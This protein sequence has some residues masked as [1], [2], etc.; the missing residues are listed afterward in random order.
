MLRAL[1][2]EAMG[3]FL[4]VFCSAMIERMR[5]LGMIGNEEAFGKGVVDFLV[6]V[7][8]YH[9]GSRVSGC[10]L[11]P[12]VSFGMVFTPKFTAIEVGL[13]GDRL[14]GGAA[15]GRRL[16]RLALPALPG[17]T[18]GGPGTGAGGHLPRL[19]KQR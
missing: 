3:T 16:R 12:A 14:R 6:F 10:H 17:S 5:H 15:G 11:N 1:V 2:F 7:G 19:G 4:L 8:F 9:I 18:Q 13:A